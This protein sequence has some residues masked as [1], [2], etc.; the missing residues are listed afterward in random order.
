MVQIIMFDKTDDILQLTGS[1][2]KWRITVL[3]STTANTMG[4]ITT[5]FIIPE[6]SMS[7]G[8]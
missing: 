8:R 3:V 4:S 7:A 2:G 1:A 5:R 6:S